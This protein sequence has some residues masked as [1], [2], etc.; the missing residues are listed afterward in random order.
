MRSVLAGTL[1]MCI[2]TACGPGT[3]M[4]APG[5]SATV[6]TSTPATTA[7]SP[8]ANTSS[9]VFLIVMEN[10]DYATAISGSY[11]KKLAGQYAVATNYHGVAHPSLPNYLAI[12]SGSTWGINDD[13]FHA[14]PAGGLGA[15]LTAAGISW[16]AYME[17]MTA[18]CLRSGYPYALK[19][20]PFPYFGSACPPEV[21]PFSRFD[22]DMA[23]DVPRFVWITPDLCHDGHDCP[24]AVADRWLQQ[25]VPKIL[26]TSAW[27]DDGLLLITW[28]EGYGSG[29]HV[30]TLV[31]HPQPIF[32]S[33][34]R[35]Y[36]HYSL[37]ATI[38]DQL[39]VSRL[40]MAARADPMDDL[41]LSWPRLPG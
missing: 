13:G 9:H 36:D 22:A 16:R 6:P 39:G 12:I 17:G 32:H 24:T 15:Q 38:E 14:L 41:L 23:G 21:V 20:N 31:I 37:L 8:S 2:L 10:R 3:A 1:L 4:H 18:D 7:T 34:N 25:I 26:A 30:L 29:N 11:T 5:P 28:D 35:P 40:G 19:H 33:S 27:Q